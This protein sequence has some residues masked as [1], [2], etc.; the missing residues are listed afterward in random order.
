MKQIKIIATGK[1]LPEKEIANNELEEK[2]NLDS[3]YIEKRTG[4]KVRYYAEKE[5]I[6][7]LAI[8]ATKDMLKKNKN[9]DKQSIDMIIVATTTPENYMPGI[10][11]KIQKE[12]Q[13]KECNAYDIL[14]GCNGFI[15][16]FDIAST[17]I[18]T[19]RA[20]RIL[21]VGVDILSKYTNPEDIGTAIILSDGAGA[22]LLEGTEEEKIYSSYITSREDNNEILKCNK[23]E[24]IFMNGKEIYKY[25]VTEPVKHIKKLLEKTHTELEEIKYIIPHQSNLRILTSIAEKI[26][27][28]KEQMYM[29]ISDV[30]NTFNASIP[31]ALNEMIEKKLLLPNDKIIIV[32]Y[33][34]GLNLGSILIEIIN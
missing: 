5:T 21:V 10:A 8:K 26:G 3:D 27:A 6:E 19:N 34:G 15:T 20:K 33:G 25:A 30:G 13:I 28:K 9:I 31:I 11:N 14:A 4:I 24:Y 16:A 7:E 23:N 2:L 18:Q 12:L 22:V 17:Y 1:Y 32:G 29:N